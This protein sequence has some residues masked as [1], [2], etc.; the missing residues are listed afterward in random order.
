MTSFNCTETF[1]TQSLPDNH[2]SAMTTQTPP[3]AVK[4][5]KVKAPH[6][7]LC[8]TS[9]YNEGRQLLDVVRIIVAEE[10]SNHKSLNDME[11]YLVS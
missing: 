1:S 6:K 8:T 4:P 11:W 9:K 10:C 2:L 7:N 5:T 3:N